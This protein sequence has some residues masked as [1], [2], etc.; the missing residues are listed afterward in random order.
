[1]KMD[2]IPEQPNN[3]SE[4]YFFLIELF[5]VTPFSIFTISEQKINLN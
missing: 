2:T 1:M 3:I 5:I 4:E